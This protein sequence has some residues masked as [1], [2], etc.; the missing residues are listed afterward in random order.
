MLTTRKFECPSFEIAAYIDGELDAARELDLESH[1]AEC[2]QCTSELTSQKQFL[3]GLNASLK[4][5]GEIELPANFTQLVVANAE[6]T[7]SGLRLPSEQ[8]N[9]VFIC[10]AL[11]LFVLFAFGTE[12]DRILQGFSVVFDQA[13]AV[14]GFFGHVIYSFFLGMAIVFRSVAAQFTVEV[15]TTVPMLLF[16]FSLMYFSRRVLRLGRA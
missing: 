12:P 13:S 5:A 2:S 3:C 1:F 4:N 9:A 10:V 16:G 11:G 14:G 15:A 8:F 6:S 7:V